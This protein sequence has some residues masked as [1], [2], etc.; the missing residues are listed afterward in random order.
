[1]TGDNTIYQEVRTAKA[2]IFQME[3]R[4]REIELAM[5]HLTGERLKEEMETYNRLTTRFEAEN[6]YACESEITGVLKGLGFEEAEF[7]KAIDTLSGGQKTRVALGKLLLS[8]AGYP[9]SG[10]AHQPPGLKFHRLAGDLSSELPGGGAHR[11]PRPL[12]S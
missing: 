4:I 7:S 6:G 3:Q 12:L 8:E 11:L 10:R 9:A 5:P 1:M 2:H